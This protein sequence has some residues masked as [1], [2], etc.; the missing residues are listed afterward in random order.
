VIKRWVGV[1]ATTSTK[2]CHHL[3]LFS[4][5]PIWLHWPLL[6]DSAAATIL[7]ATAI[8]S[9][10]TGAAGAPSPP[11]AT[12]LAPAGDS[13]TQACKSTCNHHAVAYAEA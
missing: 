7:I 11:P 13:I 12:G 5:M 6:Q 4:P 3:C 8:P 9:I 10:A 1:L 2:I